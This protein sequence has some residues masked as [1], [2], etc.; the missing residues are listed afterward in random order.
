MTAVDRIVLRPPTRKWSA[1]YRT[2]TG[3]AS[4]TNDLGS[5]NEVVYSYTTAN[6][7]SIEV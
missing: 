2:V 7:T 3:A 4:E 5:A 1:S 6:H